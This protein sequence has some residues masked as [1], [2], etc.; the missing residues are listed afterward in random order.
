MERITPVVGVG[1]A[2]VGVNISPWSGDTKTTVIRVQV[3]EPD[4]V[5]MLVRLGYTE[6][7]DERG[8]GAAIQVGELTTLRRICGYGRNP[9][10]RRS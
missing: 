7:M 2:S 4:I 5:V 9:L 10:R 8:V 3:E 6:H 1:I